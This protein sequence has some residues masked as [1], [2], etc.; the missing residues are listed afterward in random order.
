MRTEKRGGV[1]AIKYRLE[2][3]PLSKHVY[4]REDIK[5]T[6]SLHLIFFSGLINCS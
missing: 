6:V 5:F 4:D 2:P 3:M 1:A